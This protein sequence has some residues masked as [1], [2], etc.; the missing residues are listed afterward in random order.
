MVIKRHWHHCNGHIYQINSKMDNII[1][2]MPSINDIFRKGLLFK[3]PSLKGWHRY[4]VSDVLSWACFFIFGQAQCC[5][6]EIFHWAG[7]AAMITN[8]FSQWLYADN[9]EICVCFGAR[10][11]SA[12]MGLFKRC[13]LIWRVISSY[14][15]RVCTCG[16]TET[17]WAT[18]QYLP[19]MMSICSQSWSIWQTS[20]FS[21]IVLIAQTQKD[22]SSSGWLESAEPL[23][24]QL[25]AQTSHCQL[26]LW[27]LRRDKSMVLLKK[28][29]SCF[30]RVYWSPVW[31]VKTFL[32]QDCH[33][34][35]NCP[36]KIPVAVGYN[37]NIRASNLYAENVRITW[38]LTEQTYT[39]HQ[40]E[41]FLLQRF[42]G[43]NARTRLPVCKCDTCDTILQGYHCCTLGFVLHKSVSPPSPFTRSRIGAALKHC[44]GEA[45]GTSW[46]PNWTSPKTPPMPGCGANLAWWLQLEKQV[47]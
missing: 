35:A 11:H 45:G 41:P 6:N 44:C 18:V 7:M 47:T 23:T 37:N 15:F 22:C 19:R 39:S 26:Y 17:E 21:L 30:E 29:W 9:T 33:C 40:L 31:P 46:S 24:P 28:R 3:R 2:Y 32:Y 38:S 16:H 1:I 36:L 14:Y 13:D 27:F 8:I 42:Y 43:F 4:F 5:S 10:L 20:I 12:P 34:L 25:S